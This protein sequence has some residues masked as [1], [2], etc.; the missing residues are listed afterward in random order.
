VLL[1]F[2]YTT[3]T[4]ADHDVIDFMQPIYRTPMG[5]RVGAAYGK[6]PAKPQTVKAKPGYT[7][8][9]VKVRGG[10]RLEAFGVTFMKIEGKG[11][12]ATDFYESPLVGRNIA[13]RGLPTVGDTRPVVGIHGKL[14]DV[15]D[16]GI[17]SIGLIVAGPKPK[18]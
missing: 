10:G 16:E 13:P 14:N 5:E 9:S 8:A 2:Y 6:V 3:K 1:G 7:V 11:L 18:K 4:L 17:C 12:K 15:P